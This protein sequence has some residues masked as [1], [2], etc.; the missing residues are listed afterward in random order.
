MSEIEKDAFA[1]M[2][3]DAIAKTGD[4]RTVTYDPEAFVLAVREE[5]DDKSASNMFFLGNAYREYAD[6]DETRR[7]D[8]VRRWVAMSQVRDT[9]ESF[10]EALVNLMPRVRDRAYYGLVPLQLRARG[11]GDKLK[12]L[13]HTPVGDVPAV[14][15]TRDMPHTI[16]E[17]SPEQ[18]A[19]WNVTHEHAFEVAM[20]NLARRSEGDFEEIADGVYTSPWRDNF[21]ASRLLLVE[22]MRSIPV[23]GVPIVI[24]AN[25]DH[26]LVTGEGDTDGLLAMAEIAEDILQQPRPLSGCALRLDDD[27]SWSTYLPPA[28]HPARMP[29]WRLSA[30]FWVDAYHEQKQLLDMINEAS[31]DD[32][33][34]ASYKAVVAG[35]SGFS[36]AVWGKDVDTLLPDSD[37]IMI[38]SS[39]E[40]EPLRVPA[41]RARA[42]IPDL[43]EPQADVYPPR[44]RVREFP[45]D[46]QLARLAS[47]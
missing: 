14:S 5:S 13:A 20:A 33:F 19:T 12:T 11:L 46:A 26:L 16:E 42:L 21:D 10:A 34:V 40:A 37:V 23:K 27:G 45:T 38:I 15:L 31:G 47:A 9:G 22:K 1:K 25:R 30:S 2:M 18:L 3:I 44:W 32:V 41:S 8:I 28:E 17:V 7:A 43:F 36:Y 39:Q 6:A 4:K 35:E 24:A 29:L